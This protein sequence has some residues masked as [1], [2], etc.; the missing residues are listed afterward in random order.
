PTAPG[1]TRKWT[2]IQDNLDEVSM[3]RIYAGFHYRYSTKVG[4]EMGRKIAGLT[5]ETQILGATASA[6]PNR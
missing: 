5:V 2:R 4:E 1:I 6:K 3:A